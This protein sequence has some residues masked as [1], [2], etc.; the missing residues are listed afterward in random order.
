MP[1]FLDSTADHSVIWKSETLIDWHVSK[2]V[3]GKPGGLSYGAPMRWGT[4]A[5]LLDMLD[6]VHASSSPTCTALLSPHGHCE[7]DV[8][9]PASL[10]A[11]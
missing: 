6:Q 4:A 5:A 10:C 2:D 11:W 8:S 3:M 9:A 7:P 1:G